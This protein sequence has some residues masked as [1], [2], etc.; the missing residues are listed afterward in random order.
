MLLHLLDLPYS[1]PF[2]TMIIFTAFEQ[3]TEMQP[4]LDTQPL[5][6]LDLDAATW[7]EI[8]PR[9]HN[10]HYAMWSWDHGVVEARKYITHMVASARLAEH[11]ERGDVIDDSLYVDIVR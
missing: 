9:L 1:H 3:T 6:S 2:R 5:T 11:F 8:W 4:L 7:R 10:D